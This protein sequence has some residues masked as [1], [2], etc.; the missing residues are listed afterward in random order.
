[1]LLL[2]AHFDSTYQLMSSWPSYL[3]F[4]VGFKTR[5][6]KNILLCTD[7]KFCGKHG[8]MYWYIERDNILYMLIDMDEF[9]RNVGLA[10]IVEVV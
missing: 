3:S 1:M 6:M 9:Y 7:R 10:G 4:P 5:S 8:G 2:R